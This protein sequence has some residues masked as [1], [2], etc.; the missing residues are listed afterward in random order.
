MA[1]FIG[2]QAELE[3]L[4]SLSQKKTA[5]FILIRGRRRIGKSRLVKEFSKNYDQFYHFEG[6]APEKGVTA[7]HQLIA[8]SKQLSQQF[9]AP[10]A[11]YS[12]WSDALLALGE[13]VTQG[14]TL[15]LF[16]EI[17]WMGMNC[18][19]FLPQLKIFWDNQL[20]NNDQLMFIVCGSAS[21]WIDKNILNSSGFVGR[22]SHTLT[23]EE[24]PLEDCKKF[25]PAPISA[26]EKLK[27]LAVTGGIPKY[28]E[29]INPKLPA[30]ENIKQLCFSKGAFLVKEFEQIFNDLFLRDSALY[31][32][33]IEAMMDGP[34]DRSALCQ[35]LDIDPGGRISEYLDELELSGFIKRDYTWSFQTGADSKLS[36]YRLSD[37]YLRFY[38]KYIDKNLTKIERNSFQFKSIALLPEWKTI[39]GLQ[40]ENLVLNN[41][42]LIHQILKIHPDE[43]TTENPYYQRKTTRQPG[44]QVDY[45]I[46]TTYGTLYLCEIKF[47]FNT[48]GMDVIPEIEKKI[49]ALAIPKG[50]SCRPVLIHINGV[51]EDLIATDYF[52]EIIDF[53]SFL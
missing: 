45:M 52:F 10:K 49:K 53:S 8:F 29:E 38:L 13:R 32:K 11:I 20:K 34:K 47:S 9:K 7:E 50:F 51:T 22:I 33:I 48:I 42:Q 21:A 28:L 16:D 1:R 36:Q 39:M 5:S 37:N 15:I 44:C 6:L 18:P 35:K 24:L 41:R 27:V 14:K 30:E 23:L 4:I 46:Q 26:Y 31:Q 12:D 25:W 19:T 3:K 40:I 17:S 2:R 43:I